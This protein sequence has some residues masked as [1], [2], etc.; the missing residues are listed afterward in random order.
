MFCMLSLWLTFS[1]PIHIQSFMLCESRRYRLFTCSWLAVFVA[2]SDDTSDIHVPG[3]YKY[4]RVA[5]LNLATRQSIQVSGKFSN[6]FHIALTTNAD[7]YTANTMYEIV[8]GGWANT[9]SVIRYI[10]ITILV[11][12]VL[13]HD[14][15]TS[16]NPP[17]AGWKSVQPSR[18]ILYVL[19]ITIYQC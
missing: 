13:I 12:H 9:Q 14:S 15:T 1:L 6:D 7:S 19:L 18:F 5:Q 17:M 3:M 8:I 10:T 16:I 11:I 2:G 4:T